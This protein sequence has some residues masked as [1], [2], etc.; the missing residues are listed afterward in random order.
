MSQAPIIPGT[1]ITVRQATAS[2]AYMGAATQGAWE[3][4]TTGTTTPETNARWTDARDTFHT[5]RETEERAS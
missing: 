5:V 3:R 2:F 4:V 1:G